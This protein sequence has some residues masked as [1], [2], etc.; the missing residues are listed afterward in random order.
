[1]S[2]DA[3]ARIEM[4]M[5]RGLRAQVVRALLAAHPYEEPAF[6]IVELAA[7]AS[8]RGLGR[9]GELTESL[10]LEQLTR[11]VAAVLP[12]TAWGVRAAGD[13]DRVVRRVAVC[14]GSG[15]SL[16]DAAARA[17]ADVLVTSDLKHH[18]TSETL[19]DGGPALVDAGHWA[20]E[21]PWLQVAA[22]VL[23]TTV[24]TSVSRLVTDPWTV[25]SA[26]D[27]PTD[28]EDQ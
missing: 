9:V 4:V 5:P 11:H 12:R 23:A 21:W 16:A 20:T 27:L 19:A 1:V 2:E 15:G 25:H 22:G 6:D 14:G 24:E 26:A 13:P 7:P 10:S 3:D 8:P 28:T 18:A 17:G